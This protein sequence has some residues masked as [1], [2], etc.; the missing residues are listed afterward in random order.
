M[1]RRQ[2]VG[3]PLA[4]RRSR[5]VRLKLQPLRAHLIVASGH[6]ERPNVRWRKSLEIAELA[7]DFDVRRAVINN[8]TVKDIGRVE[9]MALK[10]LR[11]VD[12]EVAPFIDVALAC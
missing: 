7:D 4:R 10:Q 5:D 3:S 1:P 12:L 11:R 6:G 8:V 2:R 9:R